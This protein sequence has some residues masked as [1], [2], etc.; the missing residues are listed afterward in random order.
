[1]L[2]RGGN[3]NRG[4]N[5]SEQE[6]RDMTLLSCVTVFSVQTTGMAGLRLALAVASTRSWK[7]ILSSLS[8]LKASRRGRNEQ[9]R[10]PVQGE[11]G[12][13]LLE[14]GLNLPFFY[15]NPPSSFRLV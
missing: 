2:V 11:A 14:R 13:G 4:E 12:R 3:L 9:R 15:V 8:V 1:M 5:K 7:T 6:S 10:W